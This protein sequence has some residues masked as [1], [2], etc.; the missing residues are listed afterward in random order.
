MEVPKRLRPTL[1]TVRHL[2]AH[3]GNQC[4]FSGCAHPLIDSYGNFVAQICHIEAAELGGARFNPAMTNE[5]RRQ[6]SNLML[7]C[8]RH[9]VETDDVKR[10]PVP[11]LR[12]LKASHEAQYADQAPDA[13]GAQFDDA[14]KEIVE[15]TI[16]DVTKRQTLELPTSMTRWFRIMYESDP[17]PVEVEASLAVLIPRLEALRR[18]PVDT[19]GVLSVIVDRG[20]PSGNDLE[21]PAAEVEHATGSDGAT[22]HPHIA[23]LVRYG[24]LY[25]DDDLDEG[26]ARLV[27]HHLDG[28]HF[29][30]ELKQFCE[31]TGEQLDTFLIELRFDL[32]D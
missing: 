14:V 23:M 3:S 19:R 29:W 20:E 15:S 11:A 18:L 25:H 2:F 31:H 32:L 7:M 30:P 21:V 24:F 8:L 26:V 1:P 17:T 22:L 27:T 4:A 16:V 6:P 5:A 13:A 28:W 12:E 10:F 9:H